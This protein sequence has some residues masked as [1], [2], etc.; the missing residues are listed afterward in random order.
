MSNEGVCLDT[1]MEPIEDTGIYSVRLTGCFKG[2]G[3]EWD[4]NIKVNHLPGMQ[5]RDGK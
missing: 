1:I 3:Q 2:S 5:M 4:Y